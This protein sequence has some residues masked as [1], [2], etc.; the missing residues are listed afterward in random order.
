MKNKTYSLPKIAGYGTLFLLTLIYINSFFVRQ[1]VAVLGVDIRTAFDLSNFQVGLLYGTAFSFIYAVAGIPMGRLADITSRKWMICIGLIVWSSMTLLSGFA[2]S[3]TFLIIARLFVGLS[4]AMLSPA[5]YSYL[6]DRF[7]AE[8]R[9]T[10]F[11][12]Y[13]SGIFVG[14]GLSFIVGGAVSLHF[15]WQTAL[16]AA[17]LPGLVLFPIAAWVIKEPKRTVKRDRSAQPIGVDLKEI[18]TKKT[19]QYHL[20][21]FSFLA[22]TGY[23]ILAFVGTVFNDVFARPDLTPNFGWFIIGVGITVIIAGRV[24]DYI[25]QKSEKRRFWIGIFAAL[26][27]FPFYIAGL[28]AGSAE[29]AFVLLGMGIL[30]SSSY[31]G[32][33]AALIQYFVTGRQRA[34]AGGVY[35]FVI[36]IAGFGVGPPLTGLLMDGVF[37]GQY[38]ASKSILA[39]MSICSLGATLSFIKAMKWY[40]LDLIKPEKT[41]TSAVQNH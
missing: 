3:F 22:C 10:V 6:A 34:L 8:K 2:T 4:Q 11:S 37:T 20:I 29:L 9:A 19:V 18:L 7:S 5:V 31:N 32:V 30:I 41:V 23:T 27:G 15:D 36:S 24:A 12:F 25:A 38:A 28:F 17:S 16:I 39:V 14:V 26:G 35:L 21:G 33:G 13:A 40:E 1:I